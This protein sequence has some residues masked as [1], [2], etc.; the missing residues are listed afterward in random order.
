MTAVARP[1]A[2]PPLRLGRRYRWPLAVLPALLLFGGPLTV[3]L[4]TGQQ[5][6]TDVLWAALIVAV[7]PLLTPALMRL[8]GLVWDP[9]LLSPVWVLCALGLIVVAR[10]QPAL[11][12]AQM[13]WITLGWSAFIAIVGFPPLLSWLRRFRYAWLSLG[14]LLAMATLAFGEDVTGQGTRLWLRIGPVTLQPAEVLRVVLIAFLASALA[15]GGVAMART[16]QRTRGFTL[17]PAAYAVPMLGMLGLSLLVVVAQRDFGPA[18]LFVAAF[19]GMLYIATGRR[20]LVALALAL[21]ALGGFAAYSVSA[22][23]HGRVGAWLDPWSDPRGDGYQS[24]QAVGS[25]VFGGVTGRGPGYGFPGVVPA[26]HT[27][28]P[29]AVIAEEWGLIGTLAMV[30]LYGLFVSRGLSR[31]Q[32]AE[33]RFQQLLGAGLALSIGV[34]V[35]VVSAGVIRLLPL[36]GITSPFVSYGGSSMLMSWAMVALLSRIGAAPRAAP[37][38]RASAVV[39]RTQHVGYALLAG[40]VVVAA[41]L[42]YW[43]VARADLTADPRVAGERLNLEAARVERGRLLDRHG[44]VL[45][46]T[47]IEADGPRRVYFEPSAVHLLGFESP[48]FGAAGAEAVAGDVLMGRRDPSPD[49]TLRD[50]LHEARSGSDVHLTLDA[51]LQRVAADAMAG[52]LGAAVA[53]DPRTGDI[54]AAVSNPTFD[55]NFGEEE[56]DR[57]RQ[58]SDSPLLNRATQGLYTPGSTYK[59]VTLAAAIEAG[60]LTLDDPAEC[61]PE[62]FIDGA[63]ITNANEPPG[64]QTE[65]VA[66]AY[67][68][69]CNTFFAA[70]GEELGADRLREMSE[71]LGLTEEVPFPLET[72]AG[73][74]STDEGFLNTGAGL[75][76][77][78]FGQGQLQFSPLHLALATASIANGGVVPEPRLF[79]DE[80]PSDWRRAMSPETARQMTQ[81]MVRGVA[82]G[83]GSTAA[84]D[85][86]DVAGKTGSAEVAEGESSDALFIAFAPADDPTIAVAV[87]KERAGPGSREAGP[88]VRAIIEAWLA[89]GGDSASV[90]P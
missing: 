15:E 1:A 83:W 41:G 12:A 80:D 38:V 82:D 45:T 3:L 65:T 64:R 86:V 46:E 70:L 54:L 14:I 87:V 37:G 2:A 39:P 68:F 62:I 58:D 63:R 88:V 59:T 11:L 71:A 81:A 29:L 75:A 43:H 89:R 35:L 66:D 52:A 50:L 69:S 55:P 61:P 6:D 16:W 17:P 4:A 8:M 27:D 47:V 79:L 34:Q 49:D 31:A 5:V 53:V 51:G 25:F 77:S 19:L 48:R 13:L 90:G 23:I 42:G 60:L 36:T 74:M 85:G 44:E 57:L 76:A 40:F 24:L 21:F 7:L 18:V 10:V 56:W 26:A 33:T 67:A 84:I 78:A 28:Y 72:S 9:L 22:H 32:F 73:R 30:L 20:D